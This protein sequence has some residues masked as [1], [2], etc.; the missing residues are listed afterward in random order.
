MP[1]YDF[2]CANGHRFEELVKVDELPPCAECGTTDVKRLLSP[3]AGQLK[4][5]VRGRAAKRSNQ[6]RRAREQQRREG[7]AKK[8]EGA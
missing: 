7:W 2:E 6:T 3:V 4:I 5:E 8:R 1:I